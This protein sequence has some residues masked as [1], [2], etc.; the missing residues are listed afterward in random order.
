MSS[1]LDDLLQS[2]EL[3][4]PSQRRFLSYAALK[5]AMEA[6]EAN[7]IAATKSFIVEAYHQLLMMEPKS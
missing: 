4:T 3:L 5:T 7:D 2:I 6:L 1:A